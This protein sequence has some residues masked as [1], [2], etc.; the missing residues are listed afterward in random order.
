MSYDLSF[1]VNEKERKKKIW[2]DFLPYFIDVYL[3]NR[4]DKVI[5]SYLFMITCFSDLEN[6]HNL[7]LD[8]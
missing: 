2:F 7:F 3:N 4:Q 5:A 1:P 6:S 8:I